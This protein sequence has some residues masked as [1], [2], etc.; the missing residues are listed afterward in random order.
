MTISAPAT[1]PAEVL[2]AI[3]QATAELAPPERVYD[4]LRVQTE[5][6]LET[7]AFYLA[8]WDEA[9]AMIH[10]VAHHDAGQRVPPSETPLGE[11]PTSWVIRNRRSFRY[12]GVDDALQVTAR[13]FGSGQR[14]GSALHVPLLVGDRLV[15]VISAQ[16]YRAGA[17]T[18]DSQRLL[19]ALAA[20][21]AIALE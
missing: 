12:E 3:A 7:D 2:A 14:S 10:F 6:L 18:A 17:Y 19:E 16:A 20:H 8:L 11:G 15:G 13:A 9:R 5:R 21:A 4:T 1:L